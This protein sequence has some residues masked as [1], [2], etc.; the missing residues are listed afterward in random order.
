MQ[1]CGRVSTLSV[2]VCKHM[3]VQV[4]MSMRVSGLGH[5]CK[6]VRVSVLVKGQ[7]GEAQMNGAWMGVSVKHFQKRRLQTPLPS[8]VEHLGLRKALCTHRFQLLSARPRDLLLT[9]LRPNKSSV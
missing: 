9:I 1:A 5:T 7:A 2:R 6:L 3:L 4:C 8:A